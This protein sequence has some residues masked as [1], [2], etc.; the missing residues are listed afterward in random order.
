MTP[1]NQALIFL[2]L[3]L[4]LTTIMLIRKRDN[5]KKQPKLIVLDS[6]EEKSYHQ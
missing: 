5:A 4:I 6:F 3:M 1:Q 2:V